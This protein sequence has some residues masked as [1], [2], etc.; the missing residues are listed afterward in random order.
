[1]VRIEDVLV[2][3]SRPEV[4]DDKWAP[5]VRKRKRKKKRKERALA[6]GLLRA[7]G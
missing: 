2:M 4:R 1:L 6:A 7:P 5:C 3:D